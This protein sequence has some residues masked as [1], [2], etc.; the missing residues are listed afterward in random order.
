MS[1]ITYT[2][3]RSLKYTL[4]LTFISLSLGALLCLP[5]ATM[6]LAWLLGFHSN[7]GTP[8]FVIPGNIHWF[9]IPALTACVLAAGGLLYYRKKQYAGFLLLLSGVGCWFLFQPIYN[10]F[11]ILLWGYSYW[12]IQQIQPLFQE[13]LLYLGVYYG[14]LL[15][16]FYFFFQPSTL[17]T[18]G[19]HGT[20]QIEYGD[21]F[22]QNEGLIIGRHQ[23]T[24]EILRYTPEKHLITAAP[25]RRGKGVGSIMP[26]ILTYPNSLIVVDPKGENCDTTYKRRQKMDQDVY[27]LDPFYESTYAKAY[28]SNSFNFMD[29][30]EYEDPEAFDTC[31]I[32]SKTIITYDPHDNQFW[33]DCAYTLFSGLIYYVSQAPEFNDRSHDPFRPNMRNMTTIND[34]LRLKFDDLLA[35]TKYIS[36]NDDLPLDVKEVANE[37]LTDKESRKM[38][39]GILK[40]LKV[41]IE[42]FRSPR[43]RDTLR[44]SDFN[45]KDIIDENATLYIVIPIDKMKT[46]NKWIRTVIEL[47][48]KRTIQLRNPLDPKIDEKRILFLLDEYANLGVVSYVK[49]A[50][51]TIAGY[52]M[53]LWTFVQDLNQLK[54]IYTKDWKTFISNSGIFQVFNTNDLE[55]AEYISKTMGET[56]IFSESSSE[57]KE[58][59]S[60]GMTDNRGRTKSVSERSRWLRKPNEIMTMPM[61]EQIIK[62]DGQHPILANKVEYYKDPE[63]KN[64]FITREESYA[65][66]QKHQKPAPSRNLNIESDLKSI[67]YSQVYADEEAEKKKD[68]DTKSTKKE[69][70]PSSKGRQPESNEPGWPDWD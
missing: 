17:S 51:S 1:S 7:I 13:L 50:Y 53:T 65:E 30:V 24:G 27:V 36:N 14:Y 8:L 67:I 20:A 34:L 21:Q 70:D 3:E 16:G 35:Y 61:H 44:E 31:N 26:N 40:T 60:V 63:F 18:S 55:T 45:L 43:I 49:E 59:S 11:S 19:T 54:K 37:I 10:P 22:L 28:G 32:I 46:Y 15:V 23:K 56:T 4:R 25:T 64:L 69:R 29:L 52:G 38:L 12:D 47:L 33:M 58:V 48:I 62:P 5:Y 6:M 39:N 42:C 41:N 66:S 9:I 2:P 57:N 68:S